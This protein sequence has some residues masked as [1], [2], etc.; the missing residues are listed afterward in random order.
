MKR[1]PRKAVAALVTALIFA[2]TACG[3]EGER[4]ELSPLPVAAPVASEDVAVGTFSPRS[5]VTTG[6]EAAGGDMQAVS[7]SNPC[8]DWDPADGSPVRIAYVSVDFDGL[9]A[10]G[11]EVPDI[12]N[13]AY[14]IRAYVEEFNS[15]G[16]INGRCVS[17]LEVRWPPGDPIGGHLEVC[18]RLGQTEPLLV[19][20]FRLFD[21]GL[22]CTTFAVPIPELGLHSTVLEAT[23]RDSNY[24][25]YLDLGTIEHLVARTA[26]VALSAGALTANSRVGLLHGSG[27]SAGLPLSAA[28]DLVRGAGLNL[29]ASADLPREFNDIALL[30]PEMQAGTL[31][32]DL[33]D[34]SAVSSAH[35]A[36]L[37]EIERFYLEAA[38]G[39]NEEG[40]AAVIASSHWADVRRMMR[41]AEIVDWAPLWLTS[42]LQPISFTGAQVPERQAAN[43]IQVSTRRSAGDQVPVADQE[44]ILMRNGSA[45]ATVFNHRPHTDGW[46]LITSVCD[47]L[48]VVFSALTRIEGSIDHL[49]FIDSLNQTHY[50][51]GNG[52]L[53]S[54]SPSN[55]NGAQRFRL[56]AVDPT[57]VL[58]GWG[59]ARAA[60]GWLSPRHTMQ[61]HLVDMDDIAEQMEEMGHDHGEGSHSE[62]PDSN[63]DD[64][65][66]GH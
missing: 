29:V 59:C 48:D 46:N 65:H 32:P 23:V 15:L 39:F 37:D 22:E 12:E 42:D 2:A 64:S 57:C 36:Q 10:I 4:L 25:M 1:C 18:E 14:A 27:R 47:H 30:V 21:A 58:N 66:A 54:F 26:E 8:V 63:T 31:N 20:N 43:L 33:H 7:G 55:R 28:E 60:S 62:S 38:T 49:S 3:T 56:L 40:V 44:C 16:G 35:S 11:I 13:P 51:V 17:L 41:A 5:R 53:I 6:I 52:S 34:P 9:A 24:L 19:L 45:A 61:H 50:E